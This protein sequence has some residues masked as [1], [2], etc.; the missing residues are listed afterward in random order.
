MT[1][2]ETR[3]TRVETQLAEINDLIIAGR[4]LSPARVMGPLV[5]HEH[6][7]GLFRL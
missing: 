1:S 4:D 6:G 3:M 2:F 7:T 5:C